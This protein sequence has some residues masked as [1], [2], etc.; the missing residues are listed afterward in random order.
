MDVLHRHCRRPAAV[1]F[2]RDGTLIRDVPYNRNPALV[3]AMPTAAVALA[4]LRE[5]G[6]STAVI[7]N[8]RGVAL[9]LIGPDDVDAVNHRVEELLG[10]LGPF[11]VCVHDVEDGC[12]CR[13]PRPAMVHAA[14]ATLGVRV[15]DCVVIGDTAA[16]LEAARRAGAR[17][18]LV[19]TAATRQAEVDEARCVATDLLTAVELTIGTRR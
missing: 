3:E 14:A 1:F 8:Q 5:E 19:P 9:G 18:V 7:T 11:F 12:D 6:V 17:G 2:D 16:D 15:T 4:R 10:P 13:K